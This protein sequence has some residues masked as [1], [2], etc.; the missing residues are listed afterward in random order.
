MAMHPLPDFR[1]RRLAASCALAVAT[2]AVASGSQA[3][4]IAAVV[5]GNSNC[6]FTTASPSALDFGTIDPSSAVSA[7]ASV[8][9]GYRCNGGSA[10][11][12]WNI[13]ANDGLYPAG[14][15]AQR[16]RHAATLTQYLPY[17]LSL[18]ANGTAPRNTNRTMTLTGTVT[19]AAFQ[20]AIAGSYADTVVLTITP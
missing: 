4:N 12:A 14:A 1:W 20:T 13:V 19:P 17:S 6:R 10:I 15:G 2:S 18:P 9:I 16:M 11:V 8:T 7:T 3:V 5:L